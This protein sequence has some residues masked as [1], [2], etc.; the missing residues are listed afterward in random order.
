MLVS[1][2]SAE[3]FFWLQKQRELFG[4]FVSCA[5]FFLDCDLPKTSKV[6]TE[7][8]CRLHSLQVEIPPTVSAASGG[9]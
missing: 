6:Q 9:M 3:T 5:G 8:G 7:Q 2:V 1:V 4:T